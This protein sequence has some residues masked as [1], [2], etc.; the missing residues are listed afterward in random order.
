MLS[1]EESTE[2]TGLNQRLNRR[3]FLVRFFYSHLRSLFPNQLSISVKLAIYIGILLT[4]AMGLLGAVII[5]DQTSL[6]NRQIHSTGRTMVSQM[7][8]SAKEPL[9]A[10]DAL[11]LEVLA[12]N[13]ATSENVLGTVIYSPDLKVMARSGQ[14]PFDPYAPYEGRINEFLLDSPQSLEWRWLYSPKGELDAISFM[15]PVRFKDVTAGYVLISFSR[16]W[17]PAAPF[18]MGSTITRS[19]TSVVMRSDI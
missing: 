1:K 18:T 3:S 5:H 19:V 14:N 11:Q 17:T 2:A 6:L 15:S 4:A 12:Y 8:E 9:L 13:L 10:N 16:D 7:A